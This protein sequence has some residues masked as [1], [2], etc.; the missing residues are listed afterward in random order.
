M[1]MNKILPNTHVFMLDDDEEYGTGNM[2]LAVLYEVA[3]RVNVWSQGMSQ[4][5]ISHHRRSFY[6]RSKNR[7]LTAVTAL[8]G[9]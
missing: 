6:N 2:K 4:K 9:V 1:P 5:E 3:K 7:L 8:G